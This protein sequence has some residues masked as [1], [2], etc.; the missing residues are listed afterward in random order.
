M[1][2]N[3]F[4]SHDSVSVNLFHHSKEHVLHSVLLC[5]DELEFISLAKSFF[6]AVKSNLCLSA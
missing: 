3:T 4:F 6:T 1:L 5:L 2:T